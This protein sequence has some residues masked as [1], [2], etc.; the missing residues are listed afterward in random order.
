MTR[1]DWQKQHHTWTGIDARALLCCTS[2]GTIWTRIEQ[3]QRKYAVSQCV[4]NTCAIQVC[5]LSSAFD[6][7]QLHFPWPR[8]MQAE[9]A[10]SSA[11]ATAADGLVGT[12]AATEAATQRNDRPGMQNFRRP[13]Q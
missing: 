4:Q 6:L 3:R 2:A 13:Q 7:I 11:A 5:T 9:V 1:H 10:K 8:T 12:P